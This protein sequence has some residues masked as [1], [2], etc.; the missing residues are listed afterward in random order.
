MSPVSTVPSDSTPTA[1]ATEQKPV[2]EVRDLSVV[3]GH[4]TKAV[5]HVDIE[6][7]RGE[8]LGLPARAARA[9]R[10]WRWDCAACC[11]HRRS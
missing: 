5:D 7:A 10:R 8:T 3:Y 11:G 6:L 9:S 4:D 1:A 2:L